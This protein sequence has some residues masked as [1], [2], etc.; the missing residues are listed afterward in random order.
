M[1]FWQ[2][3]WTKVMPV[4]WVTSS[5]QSAWAAGMGG[6]TGL[7]V[8]GAA[9]GVGIVLI[10]S[11]RARARARAGEGMRIGDCGSIGFRGWGWWI[12]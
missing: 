5:N 10:G 7:G 1:R 4:L 12:G 3:W 9:D 2:N 6:V 11:R 8:A